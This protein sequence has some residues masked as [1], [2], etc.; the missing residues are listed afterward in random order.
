MFAT[1]AYA[2]AGGGQQ[3][4]GGSGMEGIVMLVIM[5]AIFYLLLIRPQQ[6]RAKQHKELISSLQAGDQVVTAGGLHGKVVAVQDLI[7]TLEIA[8]NVRIKVNRSSI[9]GTKT[10]Q[11]EE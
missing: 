7:V 1:N 9:V 3:Q 5:F 4:S 11:L 8:S 2:M 10:D 6:K